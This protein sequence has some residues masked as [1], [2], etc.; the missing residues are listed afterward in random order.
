MPLNQPLEGDQATLEDLRSIWNASSYLAIGLFTSNYTPVDTDVLSD[1]TSMEATFAGYAP[2][3]LTTWSAA[4]P[5]GFGRY[6]LVHSPTTWVCTVTPGSPET[7]YGYFVFDSNG[8]LRW[9][10]NPGSPQVISV[11]GDFVVAVARYTNKSEF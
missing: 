4:V 5:D 1:Y 8:K 9:A 6:V 3:P 2:I 10:E 7:C 11:S